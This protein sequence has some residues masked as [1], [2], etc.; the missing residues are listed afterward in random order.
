M[1][2]RRAAAVLALA[3]L[4]TVIACSGPPSSNAPST[5]LARTSWG[6]PDLQGVWRYEGAIPLERPSQ[7]Q[8]RESL[9]EQEVAER[10]QRRK[11]TGG[12]AAR[13]SGGSRRGTP[14]CCRV[15]DSGERVQQL[16]AG[17]RPAAPDFEPHR[18]RRR[19]ARRAD[20]VHARR[21][22]GRSARRRPVRR[23]A[24]R[25]LSGP[26]HGRALPHRRCHRHDVAGT[27]RR[28]QPNRAESRVS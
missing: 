5:T 23:R 1:P 15:T 7:F 4:T 26:G 18:S 13:W 28:P 21:V 8:G 10:E 20:T 16:L 19:P 17:P 14:F 6:D 24:L 25:V 3:G 27:E 2:Y 9:S 22:E 12:E 11:G